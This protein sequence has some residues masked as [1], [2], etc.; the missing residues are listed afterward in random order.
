MAGRINILTVLMTTLV[1][2]SAHA[3]QPTWSMRPVP[4]LPPIGLPLPHIGLSP[5]ENAP[6]AK[7][8]QRGRVRDGSRS[9]D[10]AHA[11]T[12]E[13][14]RRTGRWLPTYG[15][16]APL[17]Y[18]APVFVIDAASTGA[19]RTTDSASSVETTEAPSP[20]TLRFD[21]EPRTTLQLYVDG[22]YM[23][24][25]DGT[26]AVELDSGAHRVELRAAEYEPLAFNVELSPRQPVVYR[27]RLTP[28]AKEVPPPSVPRADAP[29]TLF[30]IPGCYAGNV[31]PDA[32][33]L[34]AG[35]DRSRLTTLPR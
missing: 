32:A 24:L 1:V 5:P 27:D 33:S 11:P 31:A 2:C 19:G 12:F 8:L 25:I 20:S 18:V 9:G 16:L 22:Y 17:V 14:N 35:C 30:V 21:I 23:S 34:P 29:M 13:R 28:L 4:P 7:T 26:D 3:Q 15:V 6:A 10:G